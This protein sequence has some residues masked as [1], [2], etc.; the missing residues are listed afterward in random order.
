MYLQGYANPTLGG[1]PNKMYGQP[2][3][4][5]QLDVEPYLMDKTAVSNT[6]FQ[7]FVDDTR[8]LVD[9]YVPSVHLLTTRTHAADT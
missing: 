5:S 6:Q 8:Y 7:A 9:T 2:L 3:K 1:K 4:Y